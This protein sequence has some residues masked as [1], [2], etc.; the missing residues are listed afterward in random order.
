[1]YICKHLWEESINMK[2][3]V[4]HAGTHTSS[5]PLPHFSSSV[6]SPPLTH[7]LPSSDITCLLRRNHQL[8][9][10][11]HYCDPTHEQRHSGKYRYVTLSLCWIIYL[12]WRT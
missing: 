12:N 8:A 3:K 11:S 5:S 2:S 9:P 6:P 4:R 1:M 10:R 7:S